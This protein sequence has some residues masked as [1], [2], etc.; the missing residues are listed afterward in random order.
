MNIIPTLSR[1]IDI[2]MKRRQLLSSATLGLA[3]LAGCTGSGNVEDSQSDTSNESD[4]GSSNTQSPVTSDYIT[5][6]SF[7]KVES[8]SSRELPS[9]QLL[10][11]VSEEVNRVTVVSQDGQ[12]IG[13]ATYSPGVTRSPILTGRTI[14]LGEVTIIAFDSDNNELDRTSAVLSPEIS[15]SDIRMEG[16]LSYRTF[17][18][19]NYFDLDMRALAFSVT[20]TGTSPVFVREAG[21]DPTPS[22]LSQPSYRD[23]S[24]YNALSG[25][26][27]L[28]LPGESASI[29]REGANRFWLFNI[30]ARNDTQ[31]IGDT[32]IEWD[33]NTQCTGEEIE[34]KIMIIYDSDQQHTTPVSVQFD[35]ELVRVSSNHALQTCSSIRVS[36]EN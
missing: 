31:Y 32:D 6:L 9:A 4:G 7:N 25:V 14:S 22:V 21:L 34:A 3:L 23:W 1:S 18:G 8:S 28:L 15:V 33:A 29:K 19:E 30:Q 35:G 24:R 16:E 17:E 11:T 5:D 20:N 36:G 10:A 26:Q 12:Q 13:G 2:L 27:T